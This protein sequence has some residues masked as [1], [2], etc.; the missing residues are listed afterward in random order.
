MADFAGEPGREFV[1]LGDKE[2]DYDP[3]FKLYLNTKLSNPKYTPAHFG[4]CMVVNYTVTLK[5]LEDQLLSVIV[6]YER[7]ELE[8]QR[9][10]LIQETRSVLEHCAVT[11]HIF[12][13]WDGVLESNVRLTSISS[14]FKYHFQKLHRSQGVLPWVA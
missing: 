10:R 6:G 9:E 2:V 12:D 3:N 5:G 13:S 8:E 7:R 4:R 1:M 11:A 14:T